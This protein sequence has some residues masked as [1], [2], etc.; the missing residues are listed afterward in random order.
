[1]TVVVYGATG[2]TGQMIVDRLRHSV[3]VVAAGR[4]R[5]R[6]EAMAQQFGV[7]IGVAE[8]DRRDQLNELLRDASVVVH[9]AGPFQ[10]T[11]APMLSACLGA[12]CHYIDISA[13]A[14]P[15]EY[16]ATHHNAALRCGVMLMPGA[17]ADVV[18]SD[19]LAAQIVAR[20][21]SAVRLSFGIQLP[22]TLT[23]GS[24]RNFAAH[25]GNRALVRRAGTL[26]EVPAGV[27]EREFDF[28]MGPS[29]CSAVSW[30]DLVTA[31][32]STGV[33][34]ITCYLESTAALR[35]A[36]GVADTARELSVSPTGRFAT[37][38]VA[39]VGFNGPTPAQ[40][41]NDRCRIV[42]EGE[43]GAGRLAVARI[44]LPEPYSFTAV[45]AAAIAERV[46]R[47]DF[48]VGFQTPSRV[49]GAQFIDR[50][51]DVHSEDVC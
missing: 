4:D 48:D 43:D 3:P 31:W 2:H 25:A 13:E 47:G 37:D 34:D 24:A 35:Y 45:L 18:P 27:L 19:C 44:R 7:A 10:Q 46:W 30:G 33:G 36:M 5:P 51:R 9:C 42:V 15:M 14:R 39:R 11:A 40:R 12:A 29:L 8:L 28:G 32:H 23:S 1:M 49:F 16:L 50:F 21:P 41:D 20:L 17:G 26:E 38:V 22:K 6:L